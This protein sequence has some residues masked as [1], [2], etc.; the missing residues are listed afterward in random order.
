LLCASSG[1]AAAPK[2]SVVIGSHSP[3]LERFAADELC[4]YL[5]KLFG[6]QVSPSQQVSPGTQVVFFIG[7]PKTNAAVTHALA[8]NSFPSVSDQ[9]IV[10][11]RVKSQG[12]DG[13][14]VGGGAP[15]AT[16]WAVYDLVER[17][18]VRYLVDRD[19]LPGKGCVA[20]FEN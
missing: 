7:S 8:G 20:T 13:L 3:P 10:L 15:R 6:I 18:G 14:V 9:G 17:W 16:L 19:V 12:R 5:R 1:L 11:R 2:T 4:T